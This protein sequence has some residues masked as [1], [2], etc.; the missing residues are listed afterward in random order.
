M[1]KWKLAAI[2]ALLLSFAGYGVFAN[3]SANRALGT[4]NIAGV[5]PPLFTP[6]LPSQHDGKAF[7]AWTSITKW[8][9]A[10]A[11]VELGDFKGQPTLVEV[12]RIECP[13][14]QD[15]APFL[16]QLHARYGPR[17]VKFVGIQS[18]S[19]NPDPAFSENSWPQ[20]QAWV[21][22][23][24]Y[25]WPVGF[26]SKRAWFKKSFGNNVTYPSLFLLDKNGK[27][28]FFQSGHTDAKALQLAVQLERLA[29]GTGDPKV[30][31]SE[32]LK[33][34]ESN[35]KQQPDPATEQQLQQDIS[36]YLGSNAA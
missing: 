33:W 27:V 29:P 31:S 15:A 20:V 21:K 25:T 34:I 13:H 35:L 9:N 26:D 32:I 7:P 22:A 14:C 23:K 4:G 12:F 8:T 5:S 36:S 11:P 10:P 6:P 24:G 30:R 17:G 16:A 3:S 2:A 28:V 19:D 18:P 1:E